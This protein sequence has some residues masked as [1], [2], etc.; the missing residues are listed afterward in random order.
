MTK[1][2]V[3]IIVPVYNVE[4]Y[5]EKCL[6]SILYQTFVD[7]ECILVDDCSPDN[8]PQICDEYAQKDSRIKVIHKTKNEGSSLARKTGLDASCGEYIQFVDSDDWIESEM[9]ERLY[10]KAVLGNFDIVYCDFITFNKDGSGI[11]NTPFNVKGMDKQHIICAYFTFKLARGL[12]NKIFSRKLFNN[13]V[14]P[15]FQMR[16]DVVIDAQLFL[17]A[18]RIGYEYSI[19][20][21]YRANPESIC[22]HPKRRKIN[23]KESA[24]NMNLL[25]T[26][27]MKRSDYGLYKTV[28]LDNIKACDQGFATS[29]YR[30]LVKAI[31]PY[32]ILV[33]YRY[34]GKRHRV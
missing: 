14:F 21:H 26:I 23:R 13:I 31:V 12:W 32:G 11:V 28:L 2:K 34:W 8:C 27:M 4:K 5:V 16:E 1:P 22:R 29:R 33:L 25:N 6:D 17:N 3:S 20:Y 18:E 7:F 24:A 15:V 9:T 10:R 30:K 19:L